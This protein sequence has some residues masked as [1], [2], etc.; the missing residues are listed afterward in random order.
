LVVYQ[1][2]TMSLLTAPESGAETG[3]DGPQRLTG[4]WRKR[5]EHKPNEHTLQAMRELLA[6][7]MAG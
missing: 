6:G 3:K 5:Q 2:V 7:E 1:K 4:C